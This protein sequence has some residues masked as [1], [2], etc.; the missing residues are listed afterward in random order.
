MEDDPSQA[1]ALAKAQ[2][3]NKELSNVRLADKL[4]IRTEEIQLDV[5]VLVPSRS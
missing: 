5:G 4:S 2:D 3:W 1:N